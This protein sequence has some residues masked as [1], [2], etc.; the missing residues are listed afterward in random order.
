MKGEKKKRLN[1]AQ[2]R[3]VVICLARFMYPTEVAKMVGE[4][5]GIEMT[6]Q[7]VE[8]YDPTK[9]AGQNLGDEMTKLFWEERKKY[10]ADEAAI[11]VSNRAFRLEQLSRLYR[12]A[13]KDGKDVI[14][15]QHLAQAAKERGGLYTNTRR[16]KVED[17]RQTLADILGVRQEELPER[18]N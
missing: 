8:K 6:R 9:F 14:A 3:F 4:D 7:S 15:A 11:D 13:L 5:F 1:G 12:L 2:K 17:K 18:I 10:V 16:V